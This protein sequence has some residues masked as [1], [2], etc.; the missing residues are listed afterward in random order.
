MPLHEPGHHLVSETR[1]G[2]ALLLLQE[3]LAP[4]H[5]DHRQAALVAVP[6]RALEI[7]VESLADFSELL[8]RSEWRPPWQSP[9][10]RQRRQKGAEAVVAEA[11][12]S[13]AGVE[14][15]KIPL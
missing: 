6:H 12:M 15:K 14:R 7:V 2:V 13:T 4:D 5:P 10:G 9:N 3:D 8:E 1:G 11:R